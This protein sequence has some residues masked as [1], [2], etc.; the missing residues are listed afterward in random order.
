[1]AE[2]E[3]KTFVVTRRVRYIVRAH[4]ADT[5]RQIVVDAVREGKDETLFAEGKNYVG[6]VTAKETGNPFKCVEAMSE[7][8]LIT[9]MLACR[10]RLALFAKDRRNMG[11]HTIMSADATTEM[12]QRQTL[13]NIQE[14][15]QDA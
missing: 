14:E 6:Q 8:E 10:E 4:W 1:M 5:A 12:L 7:P 2:Q 11:R 13:E 15:A 9:A 3:R